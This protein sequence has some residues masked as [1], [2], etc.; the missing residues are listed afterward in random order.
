MRRHGYYAF[1]RDNLAY[2]ADSSYNKDIVDLEMLLK[3]YRH[4][5]QDGKVEDTQHKQY[6]VREV[7]VLTD[8]DPLSLVD[9]D[10]LFANSLSLLELNI[11]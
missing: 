10:S 9:L 6:Y 8:Y 7:K 4:V 11:I 2:L 3:P 5:R 1:N